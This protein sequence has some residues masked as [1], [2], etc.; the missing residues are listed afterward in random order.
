MKR[1]LIVGIDHYPRA[2]LTGC[3]H[4]ALAVGEL[5][6]RNEDGSPNFSCKLLLSSETRITTARLYEEIEI[7]LENPADIALLYF[8]GHGT[9][10]LL[11]GYLV[12]QD[13]RHYEEGV[14]FSRIIRQVNKSSCREVIAIVDACHSGRMGSAD[15]S[16][17]TQL[18]EGVGILSGTLRH[19]AAK[20]R[21]NQ[22]VFTKILTEAMSGGAADLLGNVSLASIYTY[23]DQ[24]LSPW[25]QRPMFKAHLSR[26]SSLRKCKSRIS[27]QKLTQLYNLFESVDFQLPLSPEFEP[28]AS[29]E[30]PEKEAIFAF[31]QRCRSLG[32]VDPVDYDHL[33]DA[34]MSSGFCRL[35]AQGAYMWQRVEKGLL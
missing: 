2:P 1:A 17:A 15:G 27:H 20:E 5:L 11:D 35:T 7:L 22:G 26:M 13:A 12:S 8:A 24:L 28:S 34:A 14:S 9:E 25:E 6:Q 18:R 32:L 16:T 4:D 30:N 23:V 31:L 3:I 33:Y 10:N 29:P 21:N 19:Q